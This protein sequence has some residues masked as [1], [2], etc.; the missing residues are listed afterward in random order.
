MC[1]AK[2]CVFWHSIRENHNIFR[3]QQVRIRFNLLVRVS[4][5]PDR[6]VSFLTAPNILDSRVRNEPIFDLRFKRYEKAKAPIY[7]ADTI[8][9]L[10]RQCGLPEAM[11]AKTVKEF[12]EAVHAGKGSKINK[13]AEVLNR[14]GKAI[15]GLYAAGNAIGVLF[16]D[17]YL[18]GSQLTAAVIRG[19]VAA[20][21]AFERSKKA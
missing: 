18:D 20:R 21:E 4:D 14:D 16:Y 10:A 8:V 17:N 5:S 15:P 11:L 6:N 1:N 2:Y 7:K 13:K 12:N 3:Y 19:R 9:E